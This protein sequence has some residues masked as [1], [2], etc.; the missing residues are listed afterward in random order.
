MYNNC[1]KNADTKEK[2]F[3]LGFIYCDSFVKRN[4]IIIDI[5]KKDSL[6]LQALVKF[7]GYSESDIK[8]RII[9]NKYKDEIRTYES[10]KFLTTN[11]ELI[12]DLAQYGIFDLKRNRT[13]FPRF[14][15]EE[16]QLAF[17]SGCYEADGTR[18]STELAEGNL[19][20][21]THIKEIYKIP[22]RIRHKK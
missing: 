13:I 22:T 16:L 19:N 17:L 12:N 2:C 15:N 4:T 20:I 11:N 18:N 10:V 8:P 21:L 9:R 3:W 1:F 7:I 5:T 14:I 6:L